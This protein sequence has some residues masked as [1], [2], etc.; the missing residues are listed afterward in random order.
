MWGQQSLVLR[1]T[2]K[3]DLRS[4]RLPVTQVIAGDDTQ[5]QVGEG[6]TGMLFSQAEAMP[7]ISGLSRK[8]G[9]IE[10]D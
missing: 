7:Q 9:K 6:L 2:S 4:K 3:G 10:K 8:A 5:Q 1:K